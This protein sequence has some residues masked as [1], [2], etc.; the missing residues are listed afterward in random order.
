MRHLFIINPVAGQGEKQV[1]VLLERITAAFPQGDCEVH[2]TAGPGDAAKWTAEAARTGE[3]ARVYACGGDG[4][5]NEV[6]AAAAGRPQLAVTNVPMGSGN[7]FLRMFG[8]GRSRFTDLA[9]LR[10]GPQSPID[11]MECN[12]KLCLDVFCVG[13]DARVAHDVGRYKTYPLLSGTLAYVAALAVNV[14]FKG[15]T[16]PMSVDMGDV[17]WRGE[18]T[19]V[20]VCNGRHYGGGFM[21]V[22]E[23]Q[24][25]DG[26]LDALLVPKA[27]R[28]TFLRLVGKYAKGRYR[29][30]GGLIQDYHG[31]RIVI[32]S[33]R[34]LIAVAD[35]E[36]LRSSRFE[37]GLSPL[38]L[39]VFY[40]RGA[41][42]RES[43]QTANN[44]D[45][46]NFENE[47]FRKKT[48]V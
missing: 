18:T 26:I 34:E 24:P 2:I 45:S 9:A 21:P 1:P 27:T 41:F 43:S 12:G 32:S 17:H 28:T 7:D 39:N 36:T 3:P 22:A 38:K 15:I 47:R 30:C 6:G 23:A 25:D 31:D 8:E 4:T 42:W 10:D 13:V 35:G 44:L 19:L 46:P 5:L 14:L 20:C 16:R 40:P 37:I 29:A 33:D 48:G 11:L